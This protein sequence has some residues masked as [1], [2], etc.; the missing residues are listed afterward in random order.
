MKAKCTVNAS[1]QCQPEGYIKLILN[2]PLMANLG[3]ESV[4]TYAFCIFQKIQ[5][6]T[7]GHAAAFI[8][9][10][11]L[12]KAQDTDAI[13]IHPPKCL[14]ALPIDSLLLC[15]HFRGTE[16]LPLPPLSTLLSKFIDCV[17]SL[18]PASVSVF[19]LQLVY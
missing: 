3:T 9:T 16:N 12:I 11:L 5:R 2:I 18:V 17:V 8:H 4:H 13:F 19:L 14:Q 6:K 7:S 10:H 15:I 1:P